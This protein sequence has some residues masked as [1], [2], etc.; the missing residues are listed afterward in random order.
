MN[1]DGANL[2]TAY[3]CTAREIR[4]RQLTGQPVPAPVQKL[5]DRLD[6][7]I[8]VSHS[9]HESDCDTRQ[10]EPDKWIAAR[11]AADILGCSKR[12]VTRRASDLDGEIIG[13]RW[14]FKLHTV[15]EY[16]HG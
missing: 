10:S 9:R 13:G 8:R 16:A 1:L 11:E 2:E 7:E 4:R 6:L 5:F 14:L 3:Y 12:Q 15:L